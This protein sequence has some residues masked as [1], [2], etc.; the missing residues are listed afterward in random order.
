M[1]ASMPVP[2]RLRSRSPAVTS[3]PISVEKPPPRVSSPVA[4][5][6]TL[7]VTIERSGDEPG[8]AFTATLL[9]NSR[10]VMRWRVRRSSEALKASPSARRNSRRTTLSLVRTLPTMSMRWT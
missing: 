7:A 8:E 6:S 1:L 4:R 9:K 2:T 3:G 10:S 5:S